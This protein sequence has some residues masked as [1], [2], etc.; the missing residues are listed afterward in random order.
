[1][2]LGGMKVYFETY[3]CALNKADTSL[4]K[5]LVLNAG[6]EVVNTPD[7]A[8]VV[9]V[10]T[11]TVRMDSE[12][13]VLRRLKLLSKLYPNKKLVVAGCLAAAQPYTVLK[14]VPNASLLSPQN[15]TK[16]VEVI[17]SSTPKY[18]IRGVRD[19]SK[20]SLC[21]E[22][23]VATIPIA[24]G[25]LGDC[26]FCIVKIARRRLRSYKPKLIVET[27][28]KAVSNGAKE[29]DLTAQDTASYGID[30]GGP[31]LPEL[32]KLVLDE[33]EGDY[34]IRVGMANP[35][36]LMDVLDD[37]I[38]VLKDHRVY[39]YVHIPLQSASDKVLKIMKRRYTY[40][41]FRNIVYEIRRKVPEVCVA[42]DIIVGHPG[43][44]EEDF[45]LTV[46]ALRELM[47]DKVHIAQ[48]TLRPR[49]E[50]AALPQVPEGIKK[51]RS[52]IVNKVVEEI[53]SLINKEYVGTRAL[54]IVTHKSFRGDLIGR[55]FN[56]KP[57]VLRNTDSIKLGTYVYAHISSYTF[58]DLRS[59]TIL[60]N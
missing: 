29:I 21:F 40:D 11:C 58:Y 31:R 34:L 19:T 15:I 10:N 3:G 42:T 18:L 6:H 51:H 8:D 37:F 56:Y 2:L 43:E 36:T 47:F 12:E 59:D 50:A 25:C 60:V 28:R 55:L 54:A 39:K 24:E 13:R 1:M 33:V 14:I 57:I 7:E 27:V 49:T 22:G 38:E 5:S 48:Y 44:D 26:S 16:I 17:E 9:V 30:L 23:V 20:L 4:M 53:G 35:D 46:N 32:I 52:I 41:E 45:E